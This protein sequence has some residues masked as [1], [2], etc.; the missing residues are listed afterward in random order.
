VR[1]EAP[2]A[3]LRGYATELR[4]LTSGKAN[5]SMELSHY[6]VYRQD[7]IIFYTKD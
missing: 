1:G 4:T 3:E 6:Q 7:F 5:I 2:L